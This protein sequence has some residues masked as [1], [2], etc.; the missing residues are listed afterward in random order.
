MRVEISDYE[1]KTDASIL[2]YESVESEKEYII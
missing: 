2:P 1:I